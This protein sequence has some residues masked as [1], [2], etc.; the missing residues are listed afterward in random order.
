MRLPDDSLSPIP[1]FLIYT[2][3][4][5]ARPG[6]SNGQTGEGILRTVSAIDS[7]NHLSTQLELL[8][9]ISIDNFEFDE[10]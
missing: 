6:L 9:T 10:P 1:E 4:D 3:A 7:I 2:D 5:Q 8:N